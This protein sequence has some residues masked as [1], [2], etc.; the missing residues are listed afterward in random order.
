MYRHLCFSAAALALAAFGAAAPASAQ[1][2][3]WTGWY[4]GGNAG[5]SWSDT[6]TGTVATSGGG[7]VVIPP[8]DIAAV[9]ALSKESSNDSGFAG[10]IEGGYNW[11]SDWLLLG[12]ETEY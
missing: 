1:D 5:G 4:V 11:Q 3:S 9:S 10:G 7:T 2:T 8:A 12:I 6:S